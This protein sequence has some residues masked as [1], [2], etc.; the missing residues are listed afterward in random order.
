MQQRNPCQYG[1]DPLNIHLG[2][3]SLEHP[4]HPLSGG[5]GWGVPSVC[6]WDFAA[7]HRVTANG[8]VV[9][10]QS[11]GKQLTHGI[12]C[13]LIVNVWRYR[14]DMAFRIASSTGE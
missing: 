5:G 4:H 8:S 10:E 2:Y 6:F 9:Q 14:S 7:V 13:A 3:D 1:T 11:P 12:R